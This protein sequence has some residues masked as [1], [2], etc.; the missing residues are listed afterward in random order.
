MQTH[1]QCIDLYPQPYNGL[2]LA[3]LPSIWTE[4]RNAPIAGGAD[5]FGLFNVV[6][7]VRIA[8]QSHTRGG[9]CP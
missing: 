1:R 8:C 2:L 4:G 3:V 9:P 5:A 6:G 7:D